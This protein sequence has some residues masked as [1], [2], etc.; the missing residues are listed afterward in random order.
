MRRRG[1]K[2]GRKEGRKEE[3]WRRRDP[4]EGERLR[5]LGLEDLRLVWLDWLRTGLEL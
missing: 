3:K 2:E 4:E 1:G 5:Y